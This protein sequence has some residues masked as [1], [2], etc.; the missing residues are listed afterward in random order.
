MPIVI[1]HRGAS[2]YLPEHTLAGKELA[3]AMGAD[4]LEQ[5]VVLTRDDVPIVLHDV[6]LESVTDVAAHFPQR[7]RADGHFYAIDFDLT[8][9]RRLGVHERIDPSTGLPL[10]PDRHAHKQSRFAIAALA[11]E[12]ELI[13]GLNAVTGR[14]A[15]LYTEIKA[16]GWHRQ[17]GRDI[18]RIVLELLAQYGYRTRDD[19]LWL[20]CFDAV[21][22]KRIRTE[23]GS[24]LKLTQ[25]IGE[26]EWGE[27]DVDFERLRSAAGLRAVARYAQGVGVW[28]PHV[29]RW[30]DGGAEFSSLVADAHAAGLSVHVYTLRRDQLPAGAPDFEAVHAAL[31]RAGVD[32]VFSDFPDDSVRWMHPHG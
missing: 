3:H 31:T 30:R 25:L 8:E 1:A 6:Y 13:H 21:E 12:I 15:G 5:D 23:L 32:G 10:Y 27:A 26:N 2:G 7:R 14:R 28:I 22:L 9:L 24:A 29:V 19:A 18:S 11:E 20:Q 17:H 16:P 4:Y